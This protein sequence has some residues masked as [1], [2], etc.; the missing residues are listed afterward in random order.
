MLNFATTAGD[1]TLIALRQ[2]PQGVTGLAYP[3]P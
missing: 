3:S 1:A 2:S